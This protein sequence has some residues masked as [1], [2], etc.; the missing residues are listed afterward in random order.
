MSEKRENDRPTQST[1]STFKP[2]KSDMLD[3]LLHTL[4]DH[5]K[6]DCWK[7][8]LSIY[9]PTHRL[10]KREDLQLLIQH[11]NFAHFPND[12]ANK[13]DNKEYHRIK[14]AYGIE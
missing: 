14:E 5:W 12:S 13:R 3:A 9:V 1:Q 8:Q 4:P 10:V 7:K 2:I 11:W 6:L